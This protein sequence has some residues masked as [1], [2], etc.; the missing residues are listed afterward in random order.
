MRQI[1][2]SEQFLSLDI[3]NTNL[4]SRML[5]IWLHFARV[6]LWGRVYSCRQIRLGIQK[7]TYCKLTVYPQDHQ[8]TK[9]HDYG[10]FMQAAKYRF[11]CLIIRLRGWNEGKIPPNMFKALKSGILGP[12]EAQTNQTLPQLCF[13]LILYWVIH[14]LGFV[15][16]GAGR[17][18]AGNDC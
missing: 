8:L 3:M 17:C 15:K 12:L 16:V 5:I 11:C 18:T 7:K 9:Y 13:D 2:S 10:T 4:S 1:L 6:Y 14:C